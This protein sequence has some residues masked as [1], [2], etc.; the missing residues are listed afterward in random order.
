MG[1]LGWEFANTFRVADTSR[2]GRAYSRSGS[3]RLIVF[4]WQ[5]L[6]EDSRTMFPNFQLQEGI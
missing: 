4:P 5:H 2:F 1:I 6:N 3:Y